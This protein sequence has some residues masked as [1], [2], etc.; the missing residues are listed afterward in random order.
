MAGEV[1]ETFNRLVKLFLLLTVL[2][3]AIGLWRNWL[4]FGQS[5][6]TEPDSE[7][8]GPRPIEIRLTIRLSKVLQD[9]GSIVDT[10]RNSVQDIRERFDRWAS[11]TVEGFITKIDHDSNRITIRTGAGYESTFALEED[12]RILIDDEEADLER[13]A[14]H[15]AVTI[16][17][18][19]ADPNDVAETVLVHPKKTSEGEGD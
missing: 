12:T 7:L 1:R 19:A 11:P 5:S 8:E 18:R 3:V 4:S 13:L 17:Y 16:F 15:D 10:A 6:P 9:A 14:R 2:V